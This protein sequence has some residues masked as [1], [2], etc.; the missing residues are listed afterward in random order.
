[1]D[2]RTDRRWVFYDGGCD[3]GQPA[4]K[5]VDTKEKTGQRRL[6]TEDGD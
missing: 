5:M 4:E 3:E 6:E 2:P 1:M